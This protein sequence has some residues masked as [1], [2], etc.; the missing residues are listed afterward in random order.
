MSPRFG[1]GSF[2]GAVRFLERISRR[3]RLIFRSAHPFFPLFL[4]K[5]LRPRSIICA[6]LVGV[7]AATAEPSTITY[8]A[9][10]ENQTASNVRYSG[11]PW[12]TDPAGYLEGTGRGHRL[13]AGAAP[14][15]GDFEAGL[16]LS[17][18]REGRETVVVVDS[19]EIAVTVG[20]GPW[21]LRGRFFRAGETG[22]ELP[23]PRLAPGQSF[24]LTIARRGA[25]VMLLVDGKEI[26]RG[27]SDEQPLSELGLD[28]GSGVVRL[29]TFKATGTFA[30]AGQPAHAFNNPFGM[31]LR[32]PPGR[33]DAV[34]EPVIVREAPTN[35]CS[36]VARRNGALELYSITKPESDS[37]SV[38]RSEDG[39]LTWG[40]PQIALKIPGR[41]Y[42]AVKALEA[43]DGALHIVFHILGQGEGG[44][45]GRLYEVYH[46]T[47]PVGAAAWLEPKRIV[48]GYVGSIRGFIQL[49]SNRLV[50]G[51]A[52]AIPGREQA[53]VLGPDFGLHD[54]FVYFSDDRGSTWRQ[55]PDTLRL[56]LLTKNA[57][58]YGAVEPVLLELK[59]R[60]WMLVRDRG[61]RLWQSFS[62]DGEHWDRLEKT[63]FISSDSPAELLRLRDGRIVLFTNACQN[64]TDPRS[65]AMGG[66]EVLQAAIS[67][68]DGATWHGFREVLHETNFVGGGDRGSA[69]P[70]AAET[71]DGKVAFVSGQGDGKH[72]IVLFSPNWLEE[73]NAQDDLTAGPTGWTQYGDEGLK[74]AKQT[75]GSLALAIPL[76]SSGWC[77]AS[78]NF[79]STDSGE[80]RL[81]LRS[82]P[83]VS[84]LRVGLNDHFVRVDDAKAAEHCIYDVGLSAV[85]QGAP[86]AWHE[87]RLTWHD[88]GKGGPFALIID[89]VQV[90][91]GRARRPAQFGLNYLR[92]SFRSTANEGE[93][94]LAGV[95][96]VGR[97]K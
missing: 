44:Y 48:P 4:M 64:W 68:D 89:G 11:K 79:P 95:S 54:V 33:W 72:A 59:D 58:R 91:A 39:G 53:P 24:N 88:A 82:A 66:R 47:K 74:V 94:L 50:L 69:Y 23:A 83:S 25:Q 45:R 41:A 35:E 30:N 18:A 10:A 12:R 2:R 6:L 15:A 73:K 21:K 5:F 7:S 37:I 17:L 76:K 31:Q 93:M 85:D 19:G 81:H 38:I 36:L 13:L 92:I 96:S 40:A 22:V 20:G 71:A 84:D 56:E 42:Y 8:V 97:E 70:S 16:D 67:A 90:A 86:G 57:T 3:W 34:N 62:P 51:V 26:Y 61:G 80:L 60:V 75:D 63:G 65:Y 49:K 27:A 87:I 28:P 9:N 32:S 78:W 77:G 43:S 55:S 14:G 52:R 46:A 1:T 29:Y